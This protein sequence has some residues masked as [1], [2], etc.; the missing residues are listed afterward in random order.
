METI[1]VKS[2]NG[3]PILLT[4]ASTY[5]HKTDE[6]FTLKIS[7]KE[8]KEGVAKEV[9]SNKVWH[10][11]ISIGHIIQVAKKVKPEPDG[12]KEKRREKGE[13]NEKV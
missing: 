7:E 10:G 9:P 6:F 4:D 2:P 1:L 3:K 11:Y 13:A 12:V 8:A 5:D